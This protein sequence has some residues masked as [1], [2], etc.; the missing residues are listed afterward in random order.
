MP[1]S[2]LLKTQFI[3]IPVHLQSRVGVWVMVAH[4]AHITRVLEFHC[5]CCREVRL[6]FHPASCVGMSDEVVLVVA[7]VRANPGP[8]CVSLHGLGHGHYQWLHAWQGKLNG[9]MD[10][11]A[12]GTNI[13]LP[14]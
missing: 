11:K 9:I 10:S 4:V 3:Q 6:A 8:G 2:I 13:F 5:E 1:N 12:K 7:N 14:F